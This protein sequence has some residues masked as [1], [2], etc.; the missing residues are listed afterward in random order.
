MEASSRRL[1]DSDEAAHLPQEKQET[2]SV[3]V[4]HI[5]VIACDEPNPDLPAGQ[6]IVEVGQKQLEA[7]CFYE[8]DCDIDF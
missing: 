5:K 7:G 2:Q 1:E 6:R 4:G 3:G 8:C